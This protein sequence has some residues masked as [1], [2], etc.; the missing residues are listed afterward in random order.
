[1]QKFEIDLTLI[2][3]AINAREGLE[4]HTNAYRLFNGF[5]EGLPGIVVDRYNQTLLIFDHNSELLPTETYQKIY[6]ISHM[7]LPQIETVLLKQRQHPEESHKKGIFLHGEYPTC[8]ISENGVRFALDL[9]MNQDA[10][11]YL[12]TR[13][14]RSWL[15]E[16]MAGLRVLNTFAYTGSLGVAAGFNGAREVLQTDIN[17]NFLNLAAKSWEAN[18]LDE[19][20]HKLVTGDFFRVAGHLRH[21][22]K[23]FDCVIIDPPFFSQTSGGRVDLQKETTRLVNKIRPVVA[24]EGYL[25]LINNALFLE[26]ASFKFELDELCQSDYLQLEKIISVPPDITGYTNTI[27]DQPPVDPSPFNH[28]TKI[29]VLRVFRKDERK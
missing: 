10:S 2:R 19:E 22:N 1:M 16:N 26:G 27:Q 29:A 6:E 8:I 24:H 11:F 13:N 4:E 12:D 7:I 21:Q 20:R 9:R 28:P 23:L 14:L 17:Q 5:Y 3:E 25:V 15:R 18:D